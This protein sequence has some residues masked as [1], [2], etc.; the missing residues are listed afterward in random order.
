MRTK[1]RTIIAALAAVF[2]LGVMV[3]P[4]LASP[5][6]VCSWRVATAG[7]STLD[8]PTDCGGTAPILFSTYHDIRMV[9]SAAD[10]SQ[11]ASFM[12]LQITFN[13]DT[14]SG[15]YDWVR[16][17]AGQA[18][19]ATAH[20]GAN[21]QNF[22]VIGSLPGRVAGDFPHNAATFQFEIANAAGTGFDKVLI[23]GDGSDGNSGP[24]TAKTTVV[25][26]PATPV[27]ITTLQLSTASGADLVI[28]ARF[29]LF[30]E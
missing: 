7:V 26:R 16:D 14:T 25:W 3:V 24:S 17:N 15:K 18:S 22:G 8:F 27:A 13:N 29:D 19:G 6:Q 2:A 21:N 23:A 1:V 12:D 28:G 5:I 11:S 10:M 9:I 20:Y 30:I 4:A